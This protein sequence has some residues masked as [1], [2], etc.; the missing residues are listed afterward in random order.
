MNV[1][2]PNKPLAAVL[3]RNVTVRELITP[4][5]LAIGLAYGN[6]ATAQSALPLAIGQAQIQGSVR[7]TPN[8]SINEIRIELDRKSVPANG[9]NSANVTITL[10]DKNGA[11]IQDDVWINIEVIGGSIKWA[12]RNAS[13]LDAGWQA[14]DRVGAGESVKVVSGRVVVQWLAPPQ[15]LTG[16]LKASALGLS[17]TSELDFI[18]DVRD[19]MAVGLVE[20]VIRLRK[21]RNESNATALRSNDGFEQE[22][23]AFERSFNSGKGSA[24]TRLA[25]FVKGAISGETLLTAAY[26]SDKETR[27]NLVKDI[28]PD[29]LYPVMGDASVTQSE[30]ANSSGKLFVRLDN[31]KN[32]LLWGDF[33][34]GAQ[35]VDWFGNGQL[36]EVYKRDLGAYSRSLM[37]LRVHTERER[38]L[39]N[40][41][42]AHDNLTRQIDELPANGGSFYNAAKGN[43]VENTDTVEVITRDR[44]FPS[45]ILKVSGLQRL[46]D[47]TFDPVTGRLILR[48]ALPSYDALGNAQSLRISY[49]LESG[50]AAYWVAGADAQYKVTD[51]LELGASL[52]RDQNPAVP[53]NDADKVLRQMVSGNATVTLSKNAKIVFETARTE[54][55]TVQGLV[56]GSASRVDLNLADSQSKY[57][58][59][60]HASR[61]NIGFGNVQASVMP[62]RREAGLSFEAELTPVWT[63][64]TNFLNQ[65]DAQSG[66]ERRM[67]VAAV[68]YKLN[69]SFSFSAGVREFSDNG[70]GLVTGTSAA[71][72]NRLFGQGGLFGSGVDSATSLSSSSRQAVAPL[73]TKTAF[74]SASGQISRQISVG[75][76]LEK[77]VAED[78]AQ[79]LSVATNWQITPQTR[80]N[81]RHE[82]SENMGLN[83]D[84]SARVRTWALGF[85]NGFDSQALGR[86]DVYSEYRVHDSYALRSG[87]IASGLRTTVNLGDHW[88]LALGGERI[89]SVQDLGAN[90]SA[91]TGGLE[92][93]GSSDW[94][95][96]TRLEWRNGNPA[97]GSG[98]SQT[99]LHTT[100]V[101]RRLSNDWTL[102]ARNY[103]ASTDDRQVPGTQSQERFQL[104][105]AY[106]SSSTSSLDMVAKL[107][108]RDERN[109]ELAA[110]E[111]RKVYLGSVHGNWHPTRP[112][113]VSAKV[114]AKSVKERVQTE[115]SDFNAVL[116]GTRVTYDITPA[117]DLSL[118]GQM[119]K[120][121]G[122]RQYALGSELGY[123]V[124]RNLYL[125]FGY[126]VSGFVDKDLTGDEYTAKG[127]FMR[128]R[129]K[130]DE[131]S[132]PFLK[133]GQKDGEK[134]RQ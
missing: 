11:P 23:K 31:G 98:A 78:P 32:Y 50:G 94:R 75:V 2:E 59:L 19:L 111:S 99:W 123:A 5:A 96:S 38:L 22:L 90:N 9:L 128:L 118:M 116:V 18:P 17:A 106:R 85:S 1:F 34:T 127:V 55:D 48:Q 39:I 4:L 10:L 74:V 60:A 63:V 126:N 121:Q 84:R 77:S 88:R 8:A 79:R 124:A 73:Q 57:R 105:V 119:L 117:W 56:S 86:G 131:D 37:G 30:G 93:L 15:A 24:A 67:G 27:L 125:G 42:A 132:F 25:F 53:V 107:E 46:T 102:L 16:R 100:S 95:G 28:K 113:W 20:G 97:S 36:S 49:E 133:A 6:S 134:S 87:E 40:G 130:F 62:G 72:D 76:E 109:G 103:W 81:L 70:L 68:N 83:E 14:I 91:L 41:F 104:G 69:E 112:L 71:T 3:S 21:E 114:A 101:A 61:A 115:Q 64:S 129:F 66:A 29:Q 33:D 120:G 13:V 122:S 82:I 52:V 51:N 58:L 35:G 43:A 89:L 7:T 47:Y 54:S 65:N 44:Y 45:K 92:Y 108:L 110:T 12:G 80:I 26:D